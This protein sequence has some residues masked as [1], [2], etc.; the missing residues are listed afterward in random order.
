M[1]ILSPQRRTG[2]TLRV[3]TSGLQSQRCINGSLSLLLYFFNVR[4]ETTG[5]WRKTR[6]RLTDET[7]RAVYGDGNYER[8]D[9]TREVRIGAPGVQSTSHLMG[10][11]PNLDAKS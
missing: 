10:R 8:L 9:W 5:K 7:A 6:Y 1:E 2:V 11:A 4:D 3:S